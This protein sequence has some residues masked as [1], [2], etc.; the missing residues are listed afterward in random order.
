MELSVDKVMESSGIGKRVSFYTFGCRLN[1]AETAAIQNSFAQTGATAAPIIHAEP[2]P[3]GSFTLAHEAKDYR[4]FVDD[5]NTRVKDFNRQ[6]H[7]RQGLFPT[8]VDE[9]TSAGTLGICIRH[10]TG[11]QFVIG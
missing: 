6:L 4:Q 5:A 1:Q 8:N 10:G 2:I 11:R 7:P 3:R 9:P